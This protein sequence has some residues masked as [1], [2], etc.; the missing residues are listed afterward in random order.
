[1]GRAEI[2]NGRKNARSPAIETMRSVAFWSPSLP[3]ETGLTKI[4][5]T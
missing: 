1:L 4:D 3:E 2:A 5:L